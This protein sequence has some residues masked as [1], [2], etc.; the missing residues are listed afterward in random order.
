MFSFEDSSETFSG[1]S[2]KSFPLRF[3]VLGFPFSVRLPVI[4]FPFSVRLSVL[5]SPFSVPVL[6]VRLL[7]YGIFGFGVLAVFNLTTLLTCP[8]NFILDCL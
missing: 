6:V 3:S 1:A 4:G 5:G 7:S 8:F 2:T